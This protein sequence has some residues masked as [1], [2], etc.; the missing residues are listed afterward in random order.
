[1][2]GGSITRTLET[3]VIV[4]IAFSTAITTTSGNLNVYGSHI[5]FARIVS[6]TFNPVIYQATLSLL[7]S[8]Q[9]VI[10]FLI[11]IVMCH[12]D[13]RLMSYDMASLTQPTD[14]SYFLM[15]IIV[16][17]SNAWSC[18]LWYTRWFHC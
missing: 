8:V 17:L 4:Q 16:P 9:V 12:G 13:G 10:M 6:Q 2:R 11:M 7:T 5:L 3:G 15:H 14:H 18:F 1:M